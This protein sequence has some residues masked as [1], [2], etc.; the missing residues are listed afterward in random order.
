MDALKMLDMMKLDNM[1]L[2]ALLSLSN[3]LDI[4][5]AR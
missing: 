2:L 1:S 5:Y 3:A 4:K